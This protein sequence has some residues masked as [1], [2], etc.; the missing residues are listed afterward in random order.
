V[1]HLKRDTPPFRYRDQ[2][3][4]CLRVIAIGLLSSACE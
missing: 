1:L 2:A 3:V 4:K